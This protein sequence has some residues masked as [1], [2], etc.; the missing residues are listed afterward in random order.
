M[1][2]FI[3]LVEVNTKMASYVQEK[4]KFFVKRVVGLMTYKTDWVILVCHITMRQ[5]IR[6]KVE[7]EIATIMLITYFT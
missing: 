5:I 7:Q 2:H 4:L 3:R 1:N 6:D